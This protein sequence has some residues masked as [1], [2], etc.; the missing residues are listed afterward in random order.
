MDKDF[1][2]GDLDDW[3]RARTRSGHLMIMFSVWSRGG[4]SDRIRLGENTHLLFLSVSLPL[5]SVILS[6]MI[7][8]V[9]YSGGDHASRA[10]IKYLIFKLGISWK[11]KDGQLTNVRLNSRAAR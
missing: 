5:P 3:S 4:E 1:A 9:R 8:K 6:P 7:A 2:N 10:E 11:G